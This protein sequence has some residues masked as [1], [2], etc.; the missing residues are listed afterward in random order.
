MFK[1]LY[2]AYPKIVQTMSEQFSLNN[3]NWHLS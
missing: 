1:Q 2:F 3:F